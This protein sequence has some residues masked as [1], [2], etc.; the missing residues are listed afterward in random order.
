MTL[1]VYSGGPSLE[2]RRNCVESVKLPELQ[3]I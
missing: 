2:Q 3:T 1:G